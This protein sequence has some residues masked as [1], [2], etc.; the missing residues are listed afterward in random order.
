MSI[1]GTFF[2]KDYLGLS[3]EFLAAL[4]E[5]RARSRGAT[6]LGAA[7]LAPTRIADAFREWNSG[8][9][10]MQI[11]ADDPVVIVQHELAA[12]SAILGS[13]PATALVFQRLS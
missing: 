12:I 13:G 5:Q 4:E 9:L 1:V 3:A 11:C 6:K 10:L 8:D 7:G 2:V